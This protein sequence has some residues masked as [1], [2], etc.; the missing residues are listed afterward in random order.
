[1]SAAST[2]LLS[3]AHFPALCAAFRKP[4]G[5]AL[6]D[7]VELL[8]SRGP[9]VER[10]PR[11]HER[12]MAQLLHKN[13]EP[14]CGDV[15]MVLDLS[16]SGVRVAVP[17]SLDLALSDATSVTFRFATAGED[18]RK[19]VLEVGAKLVRVI[20]NRN[21]DGF[22]ELGFAFTDLADAQAGRLEHL[23]SLIFDG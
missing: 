18:G 2:P 6:R 14:L 17:Q 16:K 13:G 19:E 12:H 23:R 9:Q 3:E 5:A 15:V 8:L 11:R 22:L 1:M 10:A 7:E 21:G 4:G 20:S